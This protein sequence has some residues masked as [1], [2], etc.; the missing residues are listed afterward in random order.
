MQNDNGLIDLILDENDC[1]VARMRLFSDGINQNTRV[2]FHEKITGDKGCLSCG[3]CVDDCPV[4]KEKIRFV[5]IHT[6]RTSMAL[7]T[8]VG[9]ECRRCYKCINSCPQVEK[10]LKEYALGF[11]RGKKIVHMFFAM[12][13]VLLALTGMIS[14]HYGDILPG[15]EVEVLKYVH[16]ILGVFF[17]MLPFLYYILEQRHMF[18]LFRK[19]FIWNKSDW[20]WTK[21]LVYHITNH[22]KYPMPLKTEFN[23]GQ[24]VWYLYIIIMIPFLSLTGLTLLVGSFYPNNSIIMLI[25]L[26]HMI[27]A[28]TTDIFLFIHIYIKYLRNW[29]ILIFDIIKVFK[30]KRKLNYSLLYNPNKNLS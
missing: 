29:A 6:Q 16:R 19:V 30:E 11:R 5:F 9:N 20:L 3:N 22:K 12:A 7:E 8:I 14:L 17:V 25:K 13:I 18:R 4:I 2:L 15:K 23:P 21:Q 27:I 1:P 10:S 28:L 26:T 24:K